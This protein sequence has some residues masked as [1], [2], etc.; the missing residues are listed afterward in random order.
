MPVRRLKKGPGVSI[1]L[2]AEVRR[3]MDLAA[4]LP[5]IRS[6]VV[7]TM[8]MTV[9]R[10][11]R[12]IAAPGWID[13]K[14]DPLDG[15]DRDTSLDFYRKDRVYGWIQGRGLES[16]T[17]HLRWIAAMPGYEVLDRQA[18]EAAAESL[19]KKLMAV[20][21]P[22]SG[23]R[24]FFVMDPSGADAGDSG[25]KGY[26]RGEGHVGSGGHVGGESATTTLSHLFVLR[27]LL[28]YAE[29][30][31]FRDEGDRIAAEL[32]KAVDTSLRGGCLDDQRGFG[33]RGGAVYLPDRKG[34]EGQM[35]SIG[36]CE[37]LF[38][39]SRAREDFERGVRAI[40]AILEGYVNE[41]P[42][43]GTLLIDA[44][45]ADGQPMREDGRLKANPGHALE[46]VGLALQFF[47]LCREAAAT[48]TADEA[49]E[50]QSEGE[51]LRVGMIEVLLR[52][53][54]GCARV[55]RAPHGGI[56]KSVDAE[57]G[58][59]LDGNCP[60]WSSFEAVRTYAELYLAVDGE[61][62]KRL[63]IDKMWSFLRCAEDLYLEPSTTGIPVQTVSIS[64]R[65]VPVIPATPDI[66]PGYHTG[67]PLLDVHEILARNASMLCGSS[68]QAI[69][70]RLGVRLQGHIARAE[71]ADKEMD[72][73]HVRCCLLA[74]ASTQALIVSAD[75]LEFSREWSEAAYKAISTRHG[76]P[77]GN[78]FLLATHTHTAPGAID[79]GLLKSDRIFLDSLEETID[80]GIRAARKAM[81][82]TA[83]LW[84]EAAA[85][86]IGVNRR[87]RDPATGMVGMRPNPDGER[88]EAMGGLF[89]FDE[90]GLP[91]TVLVNLAVH[92]TTLGVSL[93]EVSADYPGRAVARIREGFGKEVVA[94]PI[95]GACGDV[96]PRVLDESGTEFAEGTEEDIERIGSAIAESFTRAFVGAK[97][98]DATWIDGSIL[99]I[100]TRMAEL[101]LAALPS[102]EGIT[103]L[104]ARLEKEIAV[105]KEGAGERAGF[106]GS[107]ENPLLTAETYLAWAD[108]LLETAF[109]ASRAYRGPASV[110][111]RFSLCSLGP[112]LKLFSL[113]GEAFCR[114]G[115]NLKHR[116]LPSGLIVCGYSGG[117]VGYIPTKDAF[118]EGGY[119]VEA[120]FRFYGFPGPL[121]SDTETIIYDLFDAMREE[122]LEC[123]H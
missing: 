103:T 82:P 119:E 92:P 50:G 58:S 6:I 15:K 113:P 20:C 13:M 40:R 57:T 98:K 12:N 99:S 60:W 37:L 66:D 87:L 110:S 79:L 72:P 11:R 86:G 73:L 123:P 53:A 112:A 45:D 24:A 115:K 32:R 52:L 16:L 121:S 102:F 69:P 43:T 64:G 90:A 101:P 122:V 29:Y 10:Y 35:I 61:E 74:S 93:H 109:D 4:I 18:L 38:A 62:E 36:A 27:G 44:L 21:L 114:I 14:F 116:A 17:A 84:V 118:A 83:G 65:A 68:D 26:G 75:V 19:H 47:R 54:S 41:N 63:C 22:E 7:P 76:I 91:Q 46:F 34:Y 59:V 23:I 51:G 100:A 55:G 78:I 71:P 67:M 89:L 88:D 2:P 1:I 117:T 3:K 42:V 30:R 9:E 106:A 96:R 5:L 85:E 70:P 120:A 104:K 56:V 77:E 31:N 107:H 33:P 8:R 108:G 105:L 39:Y 94:I 111:A 81:K 95:Q 49:W 48:G 25:G 97:G 28:A 80:A